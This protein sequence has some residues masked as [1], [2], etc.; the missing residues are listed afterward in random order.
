MRRLYVGLRFSAWSSSAALRPGIDWLS[1]HLVPP[2]AGL[3]L[4]YLAL[5][6]AVAI[7]LAFAVPAALHQVDH[8]LSPSGKAEVAR[9]AKHSTGVKHEILTALQ[10]RL[11]HLPKRSDLAGP[12]V[13][14]G[15]KAFEVVIGIFFTFAAA[16]YWI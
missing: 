13:G 9:A 11:A 6:A 10:K 14:V 12:A 8:A 16:A 1:R 7:A 4:H 15:R 5:L 2:A 3:A